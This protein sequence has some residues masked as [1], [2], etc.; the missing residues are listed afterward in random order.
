MYIRMHI[1]SLII[2]SRVRGDYIRRGIGL[3]TGFTGS[4]TVTHNYSVYTPTAHYSSLQ[5]AESLHCVFTGYLS[6]NT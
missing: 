3:T 5:L 1:I 2:L 4:H 6:S